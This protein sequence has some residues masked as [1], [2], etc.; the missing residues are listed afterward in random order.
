[1]TESR[2]SFQNSP[3]NA[4]RDIRTDLQ[5]FGQVNINPVLDLMWDNGRRDMEQLVRIN[6]TMTQLVRMPYTNAW[7]LGNLH[8]DCYPCTVSPRLTR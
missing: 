4:Y 7:R 2:R 8:Q 5:Y 1:M 3:N 6:S